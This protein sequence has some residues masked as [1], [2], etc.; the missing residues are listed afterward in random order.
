MDHSPTANQLLAALPADVRGRLYP[1]LE[2]VALPL[3]SLGRQ[4]GLAHGRLGIL[5]LTLDDAPLL[6]QWDRGVRQF[7]QRRFRV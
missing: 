3:E 2:P 1:K 7:L 4:V 5:R 6:V